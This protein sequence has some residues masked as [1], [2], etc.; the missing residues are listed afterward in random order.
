MGLAEAESI[1]S[2]VSCGGF[3]CCAGVYSRRPLGRGYLRR[4][5]DAGFEGAQIT[6]ARW[7]RDRYLYR[8]SEDLPEAI[9]WY[10]RYLSARALGLRARGARLSP[11][12]RAGGAVV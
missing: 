4:A 1:M 3:S 10:E 11:Q 8:E 12:I 6:L 9:K 5:A 7:L 2:E